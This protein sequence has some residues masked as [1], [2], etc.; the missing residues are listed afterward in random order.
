MSA[1]QWFRENG[2]AFEAEWRK[3]YESYTEAE[4]QEIFRPIEEYLA[5]C[6]AREHGGRT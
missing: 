5:A 3:L 2:E 6:E 4:L 1:E